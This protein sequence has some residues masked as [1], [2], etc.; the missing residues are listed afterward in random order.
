[1]MSSVQSV[2]EV[3]K[4]DDHR[5]LILKGPTHPARAG[6]GAWR[7]QG[8]GR[9]A[10]LAQVAGLRRQGRKPL[11]RN[12]NGTEPFSLVAWQPDQKLTLK[13]WWDKPKG[14]IDEVVFTPIKSAASAPRR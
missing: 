11:P 14:N 7:E 4:V 5:D 13:K 3:K 1:M 6:Q 9:E 10:Q 2:K 8:L 12:A